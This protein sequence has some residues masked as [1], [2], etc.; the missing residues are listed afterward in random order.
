MTWKDDYQ[1]Y[2]YRHTKMKSH[3]DWSGWISLIY[4]IMKSQRDLLV[5][6]SQ[7]KEV[8]LYVYSNEARQNVSIRVRVE[9]HQDVWDYS[10]V[11]IVDV[12]ENVNMNE[13]I[14]NGP[15][16][17]APTTYS[18]S[19]NRN[20]YKW[21]IDRYIVLNKVSVLVTAKKMIDYMEE[22]VIAGTSGTYGIDGQEGADFRRI[23][24]FDT[25]PVTEK[26]YITHWFRKLF[27]LWNSMEA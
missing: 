19:Y 3:R 9:W 7:S 23:W 22:G 25:I 20:D 10:S 18:N 16:E 6:K 11:P 12:S 24:S 26:Q 2:I 21:M 8:S 13:G 4:A 1:E 5:E 27:P 15:N 14:N 17:L